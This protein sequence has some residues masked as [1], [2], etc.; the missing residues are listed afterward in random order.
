MVFFFKL[1]LKSYI[2]MIVII[3]THYY[4]M[5]HDPSIVAMAAAGSTE[6]VVVC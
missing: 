5:G 6:V 4:L 2:Y 3:Q 1:L